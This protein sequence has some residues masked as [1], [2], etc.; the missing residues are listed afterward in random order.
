MENETFWSE[1]GS[2]FGEPG[3]HPHEEF[4]EETPPPPYSGFFPSTILGNSH[5]PVLKGNPH[6][7]RLSLTNTSFRPTNTKLLKI[8]TFT[9]YSEH[10]LLCIKKAG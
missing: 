7:E 2:G 10:L 6:H 4:P 1:I 8:F 3:A 5:E 9:L